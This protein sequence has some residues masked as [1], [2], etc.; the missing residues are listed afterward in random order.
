MNNCIGSSEIITKY[1]G[2][3]KFIN[4]DTIMIEVKAAHPTLLKSQENAV[5]FHLV[6]YTSTQ[7]LIPQ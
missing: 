1:D 3:T 4:D 6:A 5:I 2:S 7:P